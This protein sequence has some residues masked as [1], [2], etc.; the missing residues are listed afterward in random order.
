MTNYTGPERRKDE[1][2]SAPIDARTADGFKAIVRWSL[3]LSSL[4]M[5]CF[6]GL[7]FAGVLPFPAWTASLFVAVAAIDTCIAFVVFGPTKN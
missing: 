6:A 1:A 4:A 3:T 7:T 5:L 2:V